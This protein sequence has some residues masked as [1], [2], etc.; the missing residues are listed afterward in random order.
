MSEATEQV[1]RDIWQQVYDMLDDV[2]PDIGEAM[3]AYLRD[4]GCPDETTAIMTKTL[5][6]LTIVALLNQPI[7]HQSYKKTV[8]E[9]DN[10]TGKFKEIEIDLCPLTKSLHSAKNVAAGF[11]FGAKTEGNA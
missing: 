8:Y 3:N 7:V 1:A 4:T 2:Y 5:V 9:R 11:L 10:E 6:L